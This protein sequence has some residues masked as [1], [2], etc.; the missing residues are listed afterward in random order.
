LGTE[1]IFDKPQISDL[2]NN[3]LSETK[4]YTKLLKVIMT[5]A[6]KLINL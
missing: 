5:A 6:A 1:R 4:P 3:V 2:A